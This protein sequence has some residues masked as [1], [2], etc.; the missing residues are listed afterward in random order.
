VLLEERDGIDDLTGQS[1]PRAPAHVDFESRLFM[2]FA[3]RFRPESGS[4]ARKTEYGASF[5]DAR[6]LAGSNF[7]P[8]TRRTHIWSSVT[9]VV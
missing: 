2:D 7:L 5:D 4:P 9:D 3:A 6:K 1:V 8:V